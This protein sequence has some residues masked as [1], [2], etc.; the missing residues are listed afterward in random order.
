ML[1]GMKHD[2]ETYCEELFGPVFNLFKV[3]T[4]ED[5]VKLANHS[6][7]GLGSAVFS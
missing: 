1:E 6:E 2:S 4:D 3:K 5:A 7:Y